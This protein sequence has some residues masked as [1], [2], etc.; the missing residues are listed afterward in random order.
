MMRSQL[1]FARRVTFGGTLML[2]PAVVERLLRC[3]DGT[4]CYR[5][6]FVVTP[7]SA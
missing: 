5:R 6:I 7:V 1:A 3:A 4:P 2:L